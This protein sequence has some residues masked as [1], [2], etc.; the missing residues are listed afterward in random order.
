MIFGLSVVAALIAERLRAQEHLVGFLRALSGADPGQLVLGPEVQAFLV[1][2]EPGEAL[3]YPMGLDFD[4]LLEEQR[5]RLPGQLVDFVAG[6][7]GISES[8]GGVTSLGWNIGPGWE[9]RP[10][11]ARELREAGLRHFQSQGFWD[12]FLPSSSDHPPYQ[13]RAE[14]WKMAC[15]D[16]GHGPWSIRHLEELGEPDPLDEPE[17]DP[18]AFLVACGVEDAVRK[19]GLRAGTPDGQPLGAT[20]FVANLWFPS[21]ERDR[22][23]GYELTQISIWEMGAPR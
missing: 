3:Y 9:R 21:T 15:V 8:K 17:E 10:G 13:V 2:R 11:L 16:E 23:R 6:L 1:E 19:A 22:I 5:G 4:L 20:R 7:Q 14:G 18:E 12:A